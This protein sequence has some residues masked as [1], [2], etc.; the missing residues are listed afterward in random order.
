MTTEQAKDLLCVVCGEPVEGTSEL[1]Q[2]QGNE[3]EL[4]PVAHEECIT[5]SVD[6]MG[7]LPEY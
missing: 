3:I 1:A 5:G 4:P 2:E 7:I 6:G